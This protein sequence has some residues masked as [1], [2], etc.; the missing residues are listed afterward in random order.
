MNPRWHHST[1]ILLLITSLAAAS[2][3]PL[4][5][6]SAPVGPHAA[7]PPATLATGDA[8]NTSLGASAT[9]AQTT[10][11]ALLV[12]DS[13]VLVMAGGGNPFDVRVEHVSQQ[14]FGVLDS[15]TLGLA[16]NGTPLNQVIIALGNLT[17]STGTPVTIPE[18]GTGNLTL[19]ASGN[20][21][22]TGNSTLEMDLVL[23]PAGANKPELRYRYTLVLT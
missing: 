14:G 16:D 9:S 20:K 21:V 10:L 13:Q 2:A 18:N 22:S 7:Q 1:W 23:T 5:Q 12:T 6:E 8:G 15:L 11:D 4:V 17:Q 3:G 19:E